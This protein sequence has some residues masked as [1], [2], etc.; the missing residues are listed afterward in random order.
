MPFETPTKHDL[1]TDNE[2]NKTDNWEAL[3]ANADERLLHVVKQL[4]GIPPY[5]E[6]AEQELAR[7]KSKT[8]RIL[9]F[10][11][12]LTLFIGV[13]TLLATLWQK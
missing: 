9:I 13:L 3:Y 11:G 6:R 12:F 7:R 1:T 4:K 10:L 8:D 2:W 5:W